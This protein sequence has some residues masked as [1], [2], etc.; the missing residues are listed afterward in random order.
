MNN[1]KTTKYLDN[2][3]RSAVD[4]IVGDMAKLKDLKGDA[5]DKKREELEQECYGINVTKHYEMTLAG[6][7]PAMW[8]EGQLGEFNEP[9]TARI[10]SAWWSPIRELH[11]TGAEEDA[12]LNYTRLHYFGA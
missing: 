8:I 9:E 4:E 1:E 5:Y 7:V 3:I 10:T 11:L 2:L 12:L 6:G